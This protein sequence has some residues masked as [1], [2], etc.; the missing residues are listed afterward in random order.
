MTNALLIVSYGGPE[1]AEEVLPFLQRL[2]A[3]KN[4]PPQRI[5]AAVK[6]YE[7]CA[8]AGGHYSPLNNECRKLIAGVQ[9]EFK[10]K[11]KNVAVYWGNLFHKPLLEETLEQMHR[12]GISSADVFVTNAFTCNNRYCDALQS[13][14]S[15]AINLKLLPQPNRSRLFLEAQ[16]DTLLTALAQDSL[17][18]D[19][20][21]TGKRLVLF[22]AHSIPKNDA[23]AAIYAAELNEACR[24]IA[25]LC[26][27][28]FDWELV[29]Q[30]ASGSA[31]NWLGPDI[32]ERLRDI[33]GEG[34]CERVVVSP[35]G[36]FCENMETQY[37]LDVEAGQVCRE[38]GLKYHRATAAGTSPKICRMIA[39]EF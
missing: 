29:Y 9:N 36:F 39:D 34:R 1:R 19:L 21:D 26:R 16:T 2:F 20:S 10:R 24:C 6:K 8:E 37:D 15:G 27:E 32:K 28:D 13:F 3:G 5:D 17:A 4:V 18:Q 35:L 30:S 14:N 22:S 33:A 38:L 23:S 12:S 11:E 31:D 25:C 7:R